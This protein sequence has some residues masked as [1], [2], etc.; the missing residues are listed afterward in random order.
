MNKEKFNQDEGIIGDGTGLI[1]PNSED[2]RILRETIQKRS[3][4]M[5]DEKKMQL[6]IKGVIYRM[7]SYLSDRSLEKI[8]PVGVFLKELVEIIKV[9]HKEFATYLG[10]KNT[11]LSA[12]YKGRRRIN[13]DLAMKLGYIFN[14]NPALWLHIQNKAE[15]MEIQNQ[16][17]EEYKKYQLNDLLRKVG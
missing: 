1:N 5:S 3:S 17:E 4:E 11:N 15:L 16:S 14:M 9:P 8:I 10:I 12:F 13:H 7:E 2:F 6:R